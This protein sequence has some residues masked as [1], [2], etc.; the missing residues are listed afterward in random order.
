MF[1]VLTLIITFCLWHFRP[2][3]YTLYL[4]E[5]DSSGH[6]YGPASSEVSHSLNM[7]PAVIGMLFITEKELSE[8]MTQV[9]K[10]IMNKLFS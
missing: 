5:P 9:Q 1:Q 4:E 7:D 3:F 10:L 2:D 8:Q 6:V